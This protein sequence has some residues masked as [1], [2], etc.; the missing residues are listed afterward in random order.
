MSY[1]IVLLVCGAF[2]SFFSLINLRYFALFP[3]FFLVFFFS[4]G[5]YDFKINLPENEI[6]EKYW[7][8]LLALLVMLGLFWIFVFIGFSN[9]GAFWTLLF[10]S[11]IARGVSYVLNYTDGKHLFKYGQILLAFLILANHTISVGT[12]WLLNQFGRVI[13]EL[14]LSF[15][16]IYHGVWPYFPVE[17]D[18]YYGQLLLILICSI[19]GVFAIQDNTMYGFTFG[20]INVLLALLLLSYA[21]SYTFK[22]PST[23][24]E[25]SLRRVLV[26]EKILQKE[27]PDPF[28]WRK[29]FI[30]DLKESPHFLHSSIEYLNLFLL[31]GVIVSYLLPLFWGNPFPQLRYRT[32]IVLFAFNA[33]FLKKTQAFSTATRFAFSLVINFSLYISILLLGQ[34][35]QTWSSGLQTA[36]PRLISRNMLCGLSILYA[37][38]APLTN[39]L[40]KSD[41]I[42]RLFSSLM[43]MLLNIYLLALL[44]YNGQFIFSLIILYLGIQWTISYYAYQVIKNYWKSPIEQDPNLLKL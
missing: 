5:F 40:K 20:L 8:Y 1:V 30:R 19:R 34:Q 17:K 42:F 11:S 3:L 14:L 43:A 10:L 6:R 36:V 29:D 13:L 12:F 15:T 9:A 33:F 27:K 4:Q 35:N 18:Q 24:R 44:P 22:T 21:L 25:I 26:W 41:L 16:I 28:Q 38:H 39:Y 37:N 7:L 23:K 32:G 31:L 2:I